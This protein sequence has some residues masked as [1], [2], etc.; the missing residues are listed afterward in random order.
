M[1]Q[2]YSVEPPESTANLNAQWLKEKKKK[3]Q[4]AQKEPIKQSNACLEWIMLDNS[5]NFSPVLPSSR[6]RTRSLFGFLPVSKSPIWGI[7]WHSS[8][9]VFQL[10][11]CQFSFFFSFFERLYIFFFMV[12]LSSFFFSM[13]CSWVLRLRIPDNERQPSGIPILGFKYRNCISRDRNDYDSG[14]QHQ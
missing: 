5:A 7:C 8:P 2:P 12:N 11:N 3:A 9:S 10:I 14:E 6:V 13:F 1:L 4:L